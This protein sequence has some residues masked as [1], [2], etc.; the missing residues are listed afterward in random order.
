M[1]KEPLD[2]YREL[3]IAARPETV[4]AFLTER[5]K[6]LRW[7]GIDASL[8]A[9]PG[10]KFEFTPNGRDL[11]RGTFVEIVPHSKVVFTFGYENPAGRPPPGSTTVTI[12][13]EPKGEGTLLRLW[14]TGLT[15]EAVERHA[16]GWQHY[17]ARLEVAARGGDPG[18]D[19]LA[20]SDIVHG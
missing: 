3:Y 19:P 6:L 7:I 14:H 2:V 9:V 11:I 8:E 17:L 1:E 10:G 13:L 18:A 5:A 15:G 20:S 4:F 16:R 12:L